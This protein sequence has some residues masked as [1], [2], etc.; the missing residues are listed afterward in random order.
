MTNFDY[1]MSRVTKLTERD[2]L[3]VLLYDESS[4]CNWLGKHIQI[5]YQNWVKTLPENSVFAGQYRYEPDPTREGWHVAKEV[6]RPIEI[7]YQVWLSKQYNPEE[8]DRK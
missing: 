1:I 8:W 6:G 3:S 7:S 2:I 5:V 4:Y